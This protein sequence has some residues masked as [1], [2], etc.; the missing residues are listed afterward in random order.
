MGMFR[1][2]EVQ[3]IDLV[4]EMAEALGSSGIKVEDALEK[5]HAA[6][7]EVRDLI[8]RYHET[9]SKAERPDLSAVIKAINEYNELVERAEDALRW[10]LIQ[11]EACGF[12]THRN[13]N[14]FYPIPPKI[15]SLKP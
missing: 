15:R 14:A 6:L 7:P 13:V 12:R 2:T 5:A 8:R 3:E 9:G 10:L 1:E 11:R 4:K